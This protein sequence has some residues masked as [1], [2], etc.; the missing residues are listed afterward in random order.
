MKKQRARR[1]LLLIAALI[2][3]VLPEMIPVAVPQGPPDF[4]TLKQIQARNE[5]AILA[6]P[7]V[8]GI[9]ITREDET[10]MFLIWVNEARGIPSL[11][12]SIEGVPIQIV[13]GGDFTSGG[14]D[15]TGQPQGSHADF[16]TPPIP[17]G[18]STSNNMVEIRRICQVGTLGFRV[19]DPASG[20]I[21]YVA[22]NHIAAGDAFGCPNQA[23]LGTPQFQP[24]LCDNNCMETFLIGT[25]SR[26]VPVNIGVGEISEVDAAFVESDQVSSLIFEVGVPSSTI[27]EPDDTLIGETVQKSGRTTAVTQGQVMA[28]NF[29]VKVNLSCNLI[30]DPQSTF[31]NQILAEFATA[32]GDSGSPVVTL[33]LEPVGLFHAVGPQGTAGIASP[34][35]RVLELL[36]VELDI[37]PVVC[38]LSPSSA[39][40][41]PGTSHTL[42]ATVTNEGVPVPGV[43]VNFAVTSGPNAGR[44]GSGTTNSAGQT[45]FTYTSNGTEGTDMIQ[46]SGSASG[47]TFSCTA[48]KT[49]STTPLC[50]LTPATDTN[51]V[52]TNH[53]VTATV[54][55]GGNPV[56][57]VAVTFAVLEGP[58]LRKSGRSTTNANGQ[59][60]FTYTGTGGVGTDRIQASGFVNQIRFNCTAT[61]TWVNP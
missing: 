26:Y 11:P 35:G 5:R 45:T 4:E 29:T 12:P 16:F 51:P 58:N 33:D 60:S 1:L 42:T 6:L 59:A 47:Q 27:R 61:K 22:N 52:G 8:R 41:L 53:T 48:T 46:A 20:V 49:W 25:L 43:L 18:V 50:E 44:T 32:G 24:G 54:T 3:L 38:Q 39:I 28:V 2:C 9:G 21:G 15:C 7:G 40:N 23:D 55:R 10:L 19:R 30:P 34:L 37:P 17:M 57:G 36:G 31:V 14:V 56:S 13:R